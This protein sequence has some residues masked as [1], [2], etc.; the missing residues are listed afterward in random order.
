MKINALTGLEN[1]GPTAAQ[2]YERIETAGG[3]Q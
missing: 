3:E 1:S 2:T